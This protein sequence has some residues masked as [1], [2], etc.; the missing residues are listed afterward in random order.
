[1]ILIPMLLLGTLLGTLAPLLGL[2][3]W[4]LFELQ[5]LKKLLEAFTVEKLAFWKLSI[6]KAEVLLVWVAAF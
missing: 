4:C 6:G 1:M 3:K 2:F 5:L